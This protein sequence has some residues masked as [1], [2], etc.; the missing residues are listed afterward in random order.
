MEVKKVKISLKDKPKE[1]LKRA[2]A[3]CAPTDPWILTRWFSHSR[4]F[5][6]G[7]SLVNTDATHLPKVLGQCWE[8][9]GGLQMV[10]IIFQMWQMS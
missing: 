6:L 2:V 9:R 1:L 10:E 8:W 3:S 4:Y 7:K 5:S